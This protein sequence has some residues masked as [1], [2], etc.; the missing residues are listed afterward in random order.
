[1]IRV[2]LLC[3][4]GRPNYTWSYPPYTKNI[5]MYDLLWLFQDTAAGFSRHYPVGQ[6]GFSGLEVLLTG[7]ERD[8]GV[9]DDLP[10]RFYYCSDTTGKVDLELSK[11]AALFLLRDFHDDPA[12]KDEII[13]EIK[14]MHPKK[15]KSNS[16][17][18]PDNSSNLIQY[19][20][21][22]SIFTVSEKGYGIHDVGPGQI[23]DTD[24]I[25]RKTKKLYHI[26]AGIF[27]KQYW[28]NDRHRM[29]YNNCYAY[30][31]NFASGTKISSPQPGVYSSGQPYYRLR[32]NYKVLIQAV[33]NDGLIPLDNFDESTAYLYNPNYVIALF[34][35][36]N[37]SA[38]WDYHLY[39]FIAEKNSMYPPAWAHKPG[40]YKVR[41]RDQKGKIIYDVRNAA[42]G[43]YTKF[44]G[45]FIVNNTVIIK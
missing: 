19:N 18:T 6:L 7:K 41:K 27:N 2:T 16:N 1:M 38:R 4:S 43:I 13:N 20:E 33:M 23:R 12:L 10:H 45:F 34:C 24:F 26:Q 21:P 35:T 44:C 5:N 25:D 29:K 28:N 17:L 11:K 30:G 8:E 14:N 31:C 9:L 3:F 22:E 37:E 32:N 39:R 36:P 40:P 15:L 42:H